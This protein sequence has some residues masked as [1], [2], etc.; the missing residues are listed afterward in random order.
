MKVFSAREAKHQ[1]GRLIDTAR[2]EP[3]AG[4]KH[5]R[6]GVVV[7]AVEESEPLTGWA[8]APSK[9]RTRTSGSVCPS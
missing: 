3:V 1:F 8:V 7:L 6:P 9:R 4:K 2:A 5:G